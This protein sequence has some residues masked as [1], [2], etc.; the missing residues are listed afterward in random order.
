MF[1]TGNRNF[2]IAQVIGWSIVGFSNFAVQLIAEYELSLAFANSS[3]TMVI[4]ILVTSLYRNLIKKQDWKYWKFSTIIG[5]II[6]S[7]IL[8]TSVFMALSSFVFIY[9]LKFEGLTIVDILSNLFIFGIMFLAWTLIYFC[10]HYFNSWH[11]AELEKW[12]LAAEVK[13][14][15]LGA[16]K[17]QINPHFI[18]NA[19]NNIRALILEDPE[20][21]R[22][23]LVNFSDLFR[24]SLQYTDQSKVPLEQEIA[25][26]KQ[27]LEL[28]SIQF[29]DKLQYDIQ[30][31]PQLNQYDIPPMILQLLVENAIKHGVSQNKEGG[32]IQVNIHQGNGLLLID[33][34]NSGSLKAKA[35]LGERLG[36]GLDNIKKR[37]DL[38]YNGKASMKMQEIENHV[39]ASIQIPI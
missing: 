31:D 2:W 15:Q 18:F 5:L 6:G 24:Y 27:Y 30:V 14:A 4:G 28:L 39:V 12:K 29:E 26:V 38:I 25:V 8:L 34:K 13:D 7:T 33:V 16:L 17:S 1:K 9:V 22:T 21:A 35:T 37:L 32:T 10:V 11:N 19:L 36:V 20:K 23:M 3:L